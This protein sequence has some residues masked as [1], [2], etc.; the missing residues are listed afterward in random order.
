F[1]I[2]RFAALPAG[3]RIREAPLS[4][5]RRGLPGI[6]LWRPGLRPAKGVR[7]PFSQLLRS[8]YGSRLPLRCSSGVRALPYGPNLRQL[9]FAPGSKL[10]RV[11]LKTVPSGLRPKLLRHV[12][13]FRVRLFQWLPVVPWPVGT[14]AD[15]A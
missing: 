8:V 15:S 5:A 14:F 6:F 9:P 3:G 13:F 7:A 1:D 11:V 2:L 4:G 12:L 10:A